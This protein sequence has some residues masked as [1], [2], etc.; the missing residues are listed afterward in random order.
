LQ[1]RLNSLNR[2]ASAARATLVC[3]LISQ[4]AGS[5][6]AASI[7]L[8]WDATTESTLAGY[9]V[10]RSTQSGV[11]TTT[12]VN[13]SPI[14]TD[15]VTDDSVQ[16]G[17][18]YYYVVKAVNTDGLE[19]AASNEIA[20]VIKAAGE[21][22]APQTMRV[23]YERL[24]QEGGAAGSNGV[25]V[26]TMKDG[27]TIVSEASVP[28]SMPVREGRLY[29]EVS[30]PANTGMAMANDNDEPA[31]ISYYFT[32]ATG[33][34]FGRGS[35]TL[36]A[37][38]Q[39]SMFVTEAP[40]NLAHEMQGTLTFTSSAPVGVAAL[41]GFVNERGEFLMTTL[42]VGS[43][44]VAPAGDS[45]VFP[46]FADGGGWTT[47]VVLTNPMDV[48]LVGTVQFFDQGSADAAASALNMTVNG[49]TAS[50]FNYNIAPR[51]AVRLVTA[52]AGPALQAGSVRVT[53]VDHGVAPQGLSIFSYSNQGIVVTEA[54]VPA[55][56]TGL[57]YRT[58]VE[59]TGTSRSGLAIANSSGLPARV[60]LELAT[61]GNEPAGISTSVYIAANGQVAHFV[62][63]LF[64]GIPDGFRGTLRMSST[65]PVAAIGLRLRINDRGDSL[66]TSVPVVNE[67]APAQSDL[68][69]PLVVNGGNYTTEII[70][71][72]R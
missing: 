5:A 64:P 66:I 4:L 32:D 56:V 21:D 25:A 58:Y 51:S 28:A 52:N 45:V 23:T 11:F 6:L 12:P 10:Y 48:P 59:W 50:T 14:K 39:K 13:A 62:N 18:T 70:R 46:H 1:K 36:N 67:A 34:D 54:S 7:T 9:N 41:R 55:E 24:G 61:M 71:I 35:F 19:S 17:N 33:T 68:L 40:F 26:V 53:A 31:A 15:S 37:R 43:V 38:S 2:L 63:E 16:S 44:G 69:F 29:V 49:V 20:A 42:P 65:Q 72:S 3:V 22:S 47:Q 60:T 27:S 57:E 30:G 8:A